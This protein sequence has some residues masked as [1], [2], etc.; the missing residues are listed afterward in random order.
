M[1]VLQESASAQTLKFILREFESGT[2]YNITI[3]NELTNSEVYNED[4]TSITSNLYYNEF[5]GTFT[6]K[7]NNYYTLT[8]KSGLD[9]IYKDKIYCTNQTIS[10]FTVNQNEYITHSTTDEF[11]TI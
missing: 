5:T 10:D 3:V 7:E 8:I 2:S 4:T 9:V 11:I 1:I 6:L